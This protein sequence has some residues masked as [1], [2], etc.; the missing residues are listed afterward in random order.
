LRLERIGYFRNQVPSHS[1]EVGHRRQH[2]DGRRAE[3][4]DAHQLDRIA[5]RPAREEIL[6]Q[7]IRSG[8]DALDLTDLFDEEPQRGVDE[9]LIEL[10][11]PQRRGESDLSRLRAPHR[12]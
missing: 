12:R 2:P 8:I 9:I 6:G 1:A 3:R 5:G 11:A 7:R 4:H 10:A